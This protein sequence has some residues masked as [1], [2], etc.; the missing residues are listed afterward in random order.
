MDAIVTCPLSLQTSNSLLM[1][2]LGGSNPRN[3][4]VGAYGSV[5]GMRGKELLHHG[6]KFLLS[7]EI[8][9]QI[10]GNPWFISGLINYS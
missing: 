9:I 8:M 5:A 7:T 10:Y 6:Q 2:F 4:T 3:S 1:L